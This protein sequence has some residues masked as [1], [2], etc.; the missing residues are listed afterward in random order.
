MFLFCP[1]DVDDN[2]IANM[3]ARAEESNRYPERKFRKPKLEI[4]YVTTQN[5]E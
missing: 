2:Y 1:D 4:A 5:T 3:I